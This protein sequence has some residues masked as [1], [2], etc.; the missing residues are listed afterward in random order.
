MD[1]KRAEEIRRGLY[2]ELA[3]ISVLRPVR[4]PAPDN[5]HYDW[6]LESE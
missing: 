3:R 6:N 2:P 5:K 1:W 4:F